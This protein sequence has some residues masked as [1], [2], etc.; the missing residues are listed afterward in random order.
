MF[1]VILF[2]ILVVYCN[3]Q[4]VT[5]RQYIGGSPF[6]GSVGLLGGN[7]GAGRYISRVGPLI[8]G[9]PASYSL[10]AFAPQYAGGV[11]QYRPQSPQIIIQ[12][13]HIAGDPGQIQLSRSEDEAHRVVHEV[14]RPV[15]Q[16]VREIIQPYRRI[17]QEIRPVI[18][19]VSSTVA[20]AD[21]GVRVVA[22]SPVAVEKQVA[23][24]APVAV[25]TPV[26]VSAPV[27]VE[28]ASPLAVD[29]SP[30]NLGYY[31]QRLIRNVGRTSF[32]QKYAEYP[33]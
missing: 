4:F 24:E 16:E 26:A 20:K 23:V 22:S 7:L 5:R 13:S 30:I 31:G 27:T 2:S 29:L 6:I 17:I 10:G 9:I 14:V 3:S 33:N 25:E 18:E 32:R 19:E 1:K 12:Q 8:Q 21:D 11:I 28:D 15:I